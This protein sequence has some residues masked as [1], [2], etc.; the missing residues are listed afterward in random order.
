M[1][2]STSRP[3]LPPTTPQYLDIGPSVPPRYRGRA[4]I[5]AWSVLI[6]AVAV[7]VI[8]FMLYRVLAG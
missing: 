6:L 2:N 3:S 5:I 1:T 8:A 7:A 4:M